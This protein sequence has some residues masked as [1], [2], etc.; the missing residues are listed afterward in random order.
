MNLLMVDLNNQMFRA[1]HSYRDLTSGGTF[2]GGVFGL[3]VMLSKAIRDTSA[4]E[5]VFCRDSRPYVRSELFPEY[6]AGRGGPEDEVMVDRIRDSKR[7]ISLFIRYMA[8]PEWEVPG[9]ECDDLIAHAVVKYRH[10]F[11]R[12]TAMS[13]DSDLLQLFPLAP[14][15]QM[16]RKSTDII[17]REH[18]DRSWGMSR[19]DMILSLCL[20]GT[21]NAVPGVQGIGEVTARKILSDPVKRRA[22]QEKHAELIE[23][24]DKL[25]RLPFPSFRR[26]EAMPRRIERRKIRDFLR[27]CAQYDITA[28]DAMVTAMERVCE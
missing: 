18:Y 21:H 7:L 14:N 24:N 8:F 9:Y 17:T 27:F 1:I 26:E 10:R 4:D 19:E 11:V 13:N 15:F 20:T 3:I 12:I 2:T 5:V 6:K 23:R 25:I 28:T 22:S 16:Y